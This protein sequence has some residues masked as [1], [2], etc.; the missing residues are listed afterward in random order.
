MYLPCYDIRMERWMFRMFLTLILSLGIQ[1]SV[2]ARSAHNVLVIYS[3]HHDMPWQMNFRQGLNTVLGGDEAV[4]YFEESMDSGRFSGP[5][6]EAQFYYYLSGKYAE[7]DIDLILAESEPASMLLDKHRLFLPGVP[8]LLVNPAAIA[9]KETDHVI[10]TPDD[11]VASFHAMLEVVS[12]TEIYIIAETHTP[13]VRQELEALETGISDRDQER[14]KFNYLVNLSMEQTL[15]AVD[16]IPAEAAVFYLAYFTDGKGTTYLPRDVAIEIAKR[17]AAPV[18]SHYDT[19][20]GTGVVGGLVSDSILAGEISGN[21]VR[22]IL[23]DRETEVMPGSSLR[24]MYDQAALTRHNIPDNQLPFESKVVNKDISIWVEFREY[25]L[26]TLIVILLLVAITVVLAYAYDQIAKSRQI[27]ARSSRQLERAQSIAHIGSWQWL[28]GSP[29]IEFSDEVYKIFG[30]DPLPRGYP[31]DEF[32]SIVHPG[33]RDHAMAHLL[34]SVDSGESV[35]IEYRIVRKD[36]EERILHGRSAIAPES[37]PGSIYEGTIHDV[38]ELRNLQNSLFTSQRLE[39]VGRFAGG[40]AHH[41]NNLFTVMLGNSEMLKNK[42]SEPDDRQ[43]IEKVITSINAA[44]DMHT[45]LLTFSRNQSL[46]PIQVNLATRQDDLRRIL[47]SVPY[48]SMNL[49][50]KCDSMLWE[51]M[52]DF[53][54]L[55]NS[56]LSLIDNAIEATNR[57]GTILVELKNAVL[58]G[59]FVVR[60]PGAGTGEFIRI[61]V[62]DDGT[63]MPDDVREQ[64]FD[65]FFTTRDIGQGSGLGLSMV[66]GFVKQ[67]NGYTLIESTAEGGGTT[68]SM[69]FPRRDPVHAF[70]TV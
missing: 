55:E 21:N 52:I 19:M 66:Y 28:Q 9:V 70:K 68:V 56:L 44:A 49:Q 25:V 60:H 51:T 40:M 2:H 43:H 17:S 48:P 37:G 32:E 27:L 61:S 8:R 63:G 7:A 13:Y 39:S 20:L 4:L 15:A 62:T 6:H 34:K 22:N 57:R 54:E 23:L 58:D 1:T 12:S 3:F 59:D 45:Q 31:V 16:A 41:F 50:L 5:V 36:G 38:T 46:S 47:Q 53:D 18:F 10:V 30:I 29:Y 11:I 69:Y 67:L 14:L 42:I 64:A 26:A 35:N 65:P 33:D 24:H